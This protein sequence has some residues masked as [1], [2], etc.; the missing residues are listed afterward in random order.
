[1][2]ILTYLL[3]QEYIVLQRVLITKVNKDYSCPFFTVMATVSGMVTFIYFICIYVD[4]IRSSNYVAP[5]VLDCTLFPGG[6]P[7]VPHALFSEAFF[8]QKGKTREGACS[9]GPGASDRRKG[10]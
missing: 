9:R 5:P 3:T 2:L 10:R 7:S 4:V 1:M 6:V 8:H